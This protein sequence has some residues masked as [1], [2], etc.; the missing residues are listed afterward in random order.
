MTRAPLA[1]AAAPTRQRGQPVTLMTPW[2][3]AQHTRTRGEAKNATTNKA[4][5]EG[6]PRGGAGVAFTGPPPR[7]ARTPAGRPRTECRPAPDATRP[8]HRAGRTTTP[9]TR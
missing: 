5:P 8:R 2:P 6:A 7:A 3:A 1:A 9:P 4:K